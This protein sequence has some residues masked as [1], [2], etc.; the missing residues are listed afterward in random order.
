M[1]AQPILKIDLGCGPNKQPGFI[2]IDHFQF[3][4]VDHVLDIGDWNTPW[5]FEDNSVDEAHSSHTL[6]HLTSG[7]NGGRV[8]FFNELY[9]VLK[10][11]ATARIITPHWSNNRAYGDFDHKWPP[12][13]DFMYYYLMKEWRK[14]NAPHN[15]AETLKNGFGLSCDFDWGLSGTFD[16]NDAWVSMRNQETKGIHMGRN[17]N[18]TVDLIAI[19][20]KKG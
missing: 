10:P 3:D 17:I 8:R 2:G 6:E 5:P 13:A 16:P 18:C 1:E 20:T 9:R 11:K 7:V 12:V 15:D 19:L 14:Q 4:G